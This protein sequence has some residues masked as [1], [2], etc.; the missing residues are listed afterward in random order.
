MGL[1]VAA[2]TAAAWW[3]ARAVARV[4]ITDAL[5]GRPQG[6]Q[7]ARQ[8]AGLAALFVAI[9]VACLARADRT[10]ALL[11]G[12]GAVAI[13][14]GVLLASPLVIRLLSPAAGH[15]PVAVRLALRDLGRYQASAAAALA[16]ISLS[17]GIPVAIVIAASAAENDADLG[18]VSES[19]MLVWTRDASQPEGVSPY[20]TDDPNDSGFSPYLPRLTAADLEDLADQVDRMAAGL[21]H[22]TVT[23]MD[24]A[25]DP[26]VEPTP[27]GRIAVTLS[28]RTDLGGGGLLDIALLYVGTAEL[29]AQVG[30]DLETV[31]PAA[32]ILTVE[33]GDLWFPQVGSAPERVEHVDQIEHR[34]LVTARLVHHTGRP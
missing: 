28:E 29:L 24:I 18:N 13:V 33:T 34:L 23:G 27:D 11:L 32:D 2:A 16:G 22:P 14:V 20:Y 6:P 12:S 9:G 5:S 25:S 19:Q 26:A 8:S 4:S 3:P 17:L 7:P 10:S 15:L 21:D 30:L 31:D 1:V